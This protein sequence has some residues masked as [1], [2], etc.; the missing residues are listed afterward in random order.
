MA[1]MVEVNKKAGITKKPESQKW[2]KVPIFPDWP[3]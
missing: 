2:P 1:R 3:K